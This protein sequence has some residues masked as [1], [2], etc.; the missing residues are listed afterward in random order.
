MDSFEDRLMAKIK[1]LSETLWEGKANNQAIRD[2]LE[3]FTG[4]SC[5]IQDERLHALFLLSNFMYFGSRQVRELLRAVYRDLYRYPII[6]QIRKS[7][8]DTLDLNIIESQFRE[9]RER[10]RFLGV[11]N[12]SESGYHLL[13]YFR[14]ENRLPK[15][16]FIH[17]HQ[18]FDRYSRPGPSHLRSPEVERYIFIDD[19]CGSGNQG[20]E[21]SEIVEDIKQIKAD[22]FIAYYM[23]FATEDGLANLRNNTKF[24]D[25][26]CIFELD[27]SFKLFAS[28]SRVFSKP[29]D[30]IS[31]LTAQSMCRTYGQILSPLGS[32]GYNDC[33]L[34]LGF[35]HNTPD[36]TLPIFWYDEQS[37]PKWAPIFRRYPKDYGWT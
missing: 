14:Q 25:V 5:E 12:P 16:N 8:K 17:T 30:G 29:S 15:T 32:L 11:G 23:L 31:K 3:N 4:R 27:S 36:N 22:A 18:I 19:L 20:I 13:Y 34:L 26:Q 37:S 9:K 33:Q 35:H 7:N 1:T 21:Y 24:D 2:W 6:E 10:T 28:N